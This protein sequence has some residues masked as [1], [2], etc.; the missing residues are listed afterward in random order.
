MEYLRLFA[1]NLL[2]IFLM[3]GV[4]YLFAVRGRISP[5]PLASASFSIFSP[6]LVYRLIVE[7]HLPVEDFLR[8]VGFGLVGLAGLGA[9]AGFIANRLG[10]SRSMTAA[11]V[12]VVMLPNAGNYGLPANL[13]AFG[14]E[15]LAQA[16]LFFVTSAV[17]S[18]TLGVLVASM[19]RS[20]IGAAMA[21]LLRVPAIWAVVLAFVTVGTEASLPG[22]VMGTVHMLADACIPVMLVVLG[23][24]LHGARLRGRWGALTLAT[25]LRLGGGVAVGLLLA[26]VFGLQGVARQAGVLEAGMPS[27]VLSIILAT[28]YDVEPAFVTSV[29]LTTTILSPLTLVPLLAYLT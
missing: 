24:Q 17:T 26:S 7:S 15:G 5:R 4:G 9:L 25:T 3:T 23:M 1:K 12:L 8:M 6:F 13:L 11:M 29:V 21:G 20:S 22:P 10:W 16:S 18:Y 14:E 19:G 28:E 2:P 27:A